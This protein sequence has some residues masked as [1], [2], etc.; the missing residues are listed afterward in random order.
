MPAPAPAPAPAAALNRMPITINL[1]GDSLTAFPERI[2]DW[3]R[4]WR[5]DHL[6]RATRTR[7]VRSRVGSSSRPCRWRPPGSQGGSR[8]IDCF[9]LDGGG[10]IEYSELAP[11][12]R[13][14]TAIAPQVKVRRR[15]G[16]PPSAV[17]SKCPSPRSRPEG[18]APYTPWRSRR[19][20]GCLQACPRVGANL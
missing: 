15:R 17:Q 6:F 5:S 13:R 11:I 10:S 8:G 18:A 19:R 16:E 14:S 3:Q 12:I 7:A 4:T 2:C 1:N 9:D 20:A